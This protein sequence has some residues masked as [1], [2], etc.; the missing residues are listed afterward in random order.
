MKTMPDAAAHCPSAASASACSAE[1]N[2]VK[3][4]IVAGVNPPIDSS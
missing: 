1:V 4:A 3:L 2:E